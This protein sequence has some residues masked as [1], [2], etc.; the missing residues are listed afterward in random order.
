MQDQTLFKR[1]AAISAILS[2]PVTLAA[3]VVLLMAVDFNSEFMSNPA[4]LITIGAPASEI[5][6]WGSILELG[7]PTLLLV[8]AALYLWYWLKPRAPELVTLSTV[9]GLANLILA[10]IG[11]LLRATLYPPLMTAY[12]QAP[13]NQRDVLMAIFQG[14]TDFTFEG[15]Y[16]LEL[17]FWGIWW[18]GIGLLL[19]SERRSLGVVTV[20]LGIAFLGAGSGWL[21]RVGPLAR[22]ENAFFLVPFWVVWLGI[23]IWRRGEQRGHMVEGVVGA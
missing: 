1:I 17:I 4:G 21:L 16:A 6:R 8:P 22:L 15:L 7:A 19:R 12:S 14:V 18:L 5:F 11:A 23:V 20:I 13:E 3:T 9:F 10:A 2:A